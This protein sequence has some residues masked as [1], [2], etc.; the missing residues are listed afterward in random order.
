MKIPEELPFTGSNSFRPWNT[1]SRS[2]LYGLKQCE[3]MWYNHL[4]EYLTSQRYMNNNRCHCVF[5]KKSHIRF[6]VVAI[7]VDDM[8][9]IET[10]EELEKITAHLKL[11]LEM[12]NLEKTRYCL[13][14]EIEHRSKGICNT[15][16]I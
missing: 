14:L 5:I 3:L 2:S 9:L 10:P 16:N 11:E 13:G 12:K 15:L 6:A 1:L 7:Y 8:N 4:S